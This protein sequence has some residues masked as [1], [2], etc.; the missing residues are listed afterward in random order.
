MALDH[1][2]ARFQGIDLGAEGQPRDNVDRIAFQ[3]AIEADGGALP[4]R[5]LPA[6][7]Q[8]LRHR[9]QRRKVGLD[10]AW[11]HA[12]HHHA[13][14]V[15]P[16]AAFGQEQAGNAA[17]FLGHDIARQRPP[18]AV[19]PVAQNGR[20]RFTVGHHQHQGAAEPGAHE[21]A[22]VAYPAF[23]VAVDAMQF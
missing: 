20:D 16:F 12:G 11:G 9:Y 22:I 21:G 4:C 14:L 2:L 17:H 3:I 23:H 18:E 10:G 19:G 7:L 8:A 15:A 5:L 1:V 13:A 6:P